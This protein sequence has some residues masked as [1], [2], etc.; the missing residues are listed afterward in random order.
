VT[1]LP[2]YVESSAIVLDDVQLV[3]VPVPKAGSTAMLWA[4]LE[5][6]ELERADFT[7]SPKLEVTRSLTIHDTTVWG[8]QHRFRGRDVPAIFD[9]G[10]WLTFTVVRDPV[11]RIW[12]A[13]VS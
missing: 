13:W 1:A 5:L 8:G 10:D 9:S 2:G 4:L 11:Q 12:S 3:Y 6:V 7:R